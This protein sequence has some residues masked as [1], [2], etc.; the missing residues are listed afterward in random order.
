LAIAGV[1]IGRSRLPPDDRVVGNLGIIVT[2]DRSA[3][4]SWRSPHIGGHQLDR[5]VDGGGLTGFE[6]DMTAKAV[7]GSRTRENRNAMVWRQVRHSLHV[8][9]QTDG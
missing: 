9:D 7:S 8:C 5:V 6:W 3:P 2:C 1:R 4:G